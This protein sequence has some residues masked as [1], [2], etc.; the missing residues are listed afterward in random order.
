MYVPAKKLKNL[1]LLRSRFFHLA[2]PIVYFYHMV[3][4]LRGW[5]GIYFINVKAI[6][7]VVP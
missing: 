1:L 5:A 6:I 3:N 7:R 4:I 2:T